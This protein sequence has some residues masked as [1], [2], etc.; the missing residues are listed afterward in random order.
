MLLSPFFF[1]RGYTFK[2]DSKSIVSD[3]LTSNTP[4]LLSYPIFIRSFSF[5][6]TFVVVVLL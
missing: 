4:Q 2:L 6:F 5:Y 1:A 3:S